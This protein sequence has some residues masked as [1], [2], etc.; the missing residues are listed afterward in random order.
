MTILYVLMCTLGHLYEPGM[1]RVYYFMPMTTVFFV[2]VFWMI[3]RIASLTSQPSLKKLEAAMAL[4]VLS[5]V[6]AIPANQSII[7]N[8]I[9]N[10]DRAAS[11]LMIEILQKKIPLR[12]GYPRLSIDGRRFIQAAIFKDWK[13][14]SATEMFDFSK[15][16][17]FLGATKAKTIQEL[18]QQ[19]PDIQF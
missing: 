6:G 7:K 14:E 9:M 5:A 2:H 17:V 1:L 3:I 11:E 18:E 19:H 16:P 10:G 8:S 13:F 4:L 15:G 12:E